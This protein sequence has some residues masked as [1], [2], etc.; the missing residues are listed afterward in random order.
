MI[1]MDYGDAVHKKNLETAFCALLSD[2]DRRQKEWVKLRKNLYGRN[3]T[4]KK[5]LPTKLKKMMMNLELDVW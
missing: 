1:K 4:F 5:L 3:A 2:E